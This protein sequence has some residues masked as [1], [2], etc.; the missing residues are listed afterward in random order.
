VGLWEKS[1]G[2]ERRRSGDYILRSGEDAL[3][4]HA[5]GRIA[6]PAEPR[7]LGTHMG[8]VTT[9][10]T[11]GGRHRF[12][13]LR[14]VSNV[15]LSV[16]DLASHVRALKP[17]E[18]SATVWAPFTHATVATVARVPHRLC[19]PRSVLTCRELPSRTF[20]PLDRRTPALHSTPWPTHTQSCRPSCRSWSTNWRRATSQPR[21]P[22][23]PSP[24]TA[25]CISPTRSGAS[26]ELG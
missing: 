12:A 18:S 16:P 8:R 3:S 1:F 22:S 26:A 21:G 14:L 6:E 19:A 23:I 7:H 4:Q 11:N 10:L 2:R 25:V 13:K 9:G 15:I 5:F 20:A 24:R 17:G